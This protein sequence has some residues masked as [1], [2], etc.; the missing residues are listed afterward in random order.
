MTRTLNR[1]TVIIALTALTA[2]AT[3]DGMGTDISKAGKAI[4][5]SAS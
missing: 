1:I 2:C 4:S 3:V 5:K